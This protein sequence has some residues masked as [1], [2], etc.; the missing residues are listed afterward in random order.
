MP[1][2]IWMRVDELPMSSIGWAISSGL[3]DCERSRQTDLSRWIGKP[4]DNEII[5]K[6]ILA[7][8]GPPSRAYSFDDAY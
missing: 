4:K 3:M 8:P 5:R 7:L 2:N 1:S 6:D